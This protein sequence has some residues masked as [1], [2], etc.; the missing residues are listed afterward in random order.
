MT[1]N[2]NAIFGDSFHVGSGCYST[3]AYQD[4]LK[5]ARKMFDMAGDYGYKLNLLDIGGVS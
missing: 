3:V 2:S 4:A 5:L 1:N